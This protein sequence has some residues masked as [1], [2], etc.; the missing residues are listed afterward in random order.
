MEIDYTLLLDWP[1]ASQVRIFTSVDINKI[2]YLEAKDNY[3]NS[4]KETMQL[5]EDLQS[6]LVAQVASIIKVARGFGSN[7]RLNKSIKPI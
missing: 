5:I 3:E 1:E 7:S 4:L 6:N 2:L